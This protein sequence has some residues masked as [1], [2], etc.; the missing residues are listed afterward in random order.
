MAYQILPERTTCLLF[1]QRGDTSKGTSW[2]S[3]RGTRG[4]RGKF[5]K[6]YSIIDENQLLLGETTHKECGAVA[7]LA[8]ILAVSGNARGSTGAPCAGSAVARPPVV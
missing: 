8:G 5:G 7:E 6:T 1:I 2:G 3:P 4:L